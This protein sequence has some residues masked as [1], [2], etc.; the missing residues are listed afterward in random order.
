MAKKRQ[1]KQAVK[2]IEF[3]TEQW[4]VVRKLVVQQHSWG[5]I[6]AKVGVQAKYLR[7]ESLRRGLDTVKYRGPGAMEKPLSALE[8]QPVEVL[9]AVEEE[10][11]PVAQS[12]DA[13]NLQADDPPPDP[14]RK[15]DFEDP[16][17]V[18]VA[19][20]H[21]LTNM[22][23]GI[24]RVI[25]EPDSLTYMTAA[26]P[27]SCFAQAA[28]REKWSIK[29]YRNALMDIAKLAQGAMPYR[30][31]TLSAVAVTDMD[32]S[33]GIAGMSDK[34]K[35]RKLAQLMKQAKVVAQQ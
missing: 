25:L 14:V 2:G 20:R 24:E 15:I 11:G 30:H 6:A 22:A 27:V 23:L 7:A 17:D 34:E 3:T 31:P 1:Q 13:P 21:K 10:L 26:D 4:E 33:N 5:Q 18:L 35:E 32:A 19:V 9:D 29:E 16:I 28:K 12:P 8:F